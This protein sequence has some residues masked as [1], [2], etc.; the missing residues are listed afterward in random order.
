M[1]GYLIGLAVSGLII[2]ALGRLA[3]PGRQPMGCFMTVLVGIGGSF[4]GGLVG[5]ALFNRPG[6]FILAVLCSAAIV[7]VISRVSR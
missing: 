1:I 7:F 6:G 3:I 2:G 4:L 5:E